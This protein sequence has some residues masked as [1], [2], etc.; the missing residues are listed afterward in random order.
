MANLT[1]KTNAILQRLPH[2]YNPQEGGELLLQFVDMFGRRIERGETDLYEVLH[3]HHVETADNV[4][5]RGYIAPPEKRGDLDKIF[6]LYLEVIGGT[7]QL[8]KMSPRFLNRSINTRR[9]ARTLLEEQSPVTGVLQVRFQPETW[10]LL[11]R[12]HVRNTLFTAHEMQPGFALALLLGDPPTAR[13]LRGRLSEP[14]RQLLNAYTGGE[15]IDPRLQDALAN[16]MNRSLLRDPALYRNNADA[17]DQLPR[18]PATWALLRGIYRDFLRARYL[19]VKAEEIQVG[20]AQA[21]LDDMPGVIHYLRE[22]LSATTWELLSAYTGG[23]AL[24]P[25]LQ[26]ALADDVNRTIQRGLAQSS[27]NVDEFELLVRRLYEEFLRSQYIIASDPVQQQ[28]LLENLDQAEPISIPPGD[29]LARLNRMLLDTA[30]A[31]DGATRP[32]GFASRNIP[33]AEEV[34]NALVR[35]LN[36]L[37]EGPEL[38]TPTLFPDLVEDYPAFQQRYGNDTLWLN[39]V[40][41]E[42]AFPNEIEKSHAPYQERLRGLIQVLRNGASTREGIVA[43][44]A[45]NLGIVGD[46]PA[47]RLQRQRIRVEE[48][49]PAS[50]LNTYP[51]VK[52]YSK[53]MADHTSSEIEIV[54]PNLVPVVPEIRLE[55][56]IGG[57]TANSSIQFSNWT[58]VNVTTQQRSLY[59]GVLQD[60]DVLTY[61]SDRS[62]TLN[63][64]STQIIGETPL[65]PP[66]K[67]TLHVEAL[68]G[69][70]SGRFDKTLFD[71]TTFESEEGAASRFVESGHFDETVFD[72]V[73]FD[74]ATLD[75][76]SPEQIADTSID[77]EITL[78]KLTPGNFMV[79]VPW[80][81]GDFPDDPNDAGSHPRNQIRYII[82]KVK[83]AGV[84]AGITYEKLLTEAHELSEQWQLNGQPQLFADA[85]DLRE[86]PPSLA[87]NG[88]SERETHDL[89][90]TLHV[91]GVFDYTG[92]DSLNTFA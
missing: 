7:S 81:L 47:D 80:D 23:G 78:T 32:W 24:D 11:E 1:G 57:N 60:R 37:L 69:I 61:F 13:Y 45:A 70:P 51:E 74:R 92:F 39:R 71:F 8:V 85:H 29:D 18:D 26:A 41:L 54:N 21:L 55:V 64:V 5:S 91:S 33:A 10:Q 87:Q 9:L 44:V 49:A 66:G 17:F 72:Q 59:D 15:E 82:D 89:T 40:V 42:R 3:A 77:L 14:T 38:Y 88:G 83:A 34:R 20:F 65:L 30:F 28:W 25:R 35:E 53:F 68:T 50:Q 52:I 22:Q 79:R 48:Y 19:S 46:S 62:V 76:P 27:A 31:R 16:D 84:F 12:Y 63:G 75:H 58:V 4:G 36:D 56:H 90:D 43:I 6:A 73:A 67:S 2:F 86:S